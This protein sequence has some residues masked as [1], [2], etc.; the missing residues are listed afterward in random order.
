MGRQRGVAFG[1]L[2]L[3]DLIQFHTESTKQAMARKWLSRANFGHVQPH[4]KVQ[5][6]TLH[7]FS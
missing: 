5:N 7:E 2:L 4:F 1:D 3:I 6:C